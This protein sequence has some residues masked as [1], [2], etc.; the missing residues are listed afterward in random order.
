MT[1]T[2]LLRMQRLARPPPAILRHTLP[3]MR[4]A[5]TVVQ[6]FS[7]LVRFFAVRFGLLF[8]EE[9]VRENAV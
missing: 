3:T 4:T 7:Y 5:S 1:I 8:V 2:R 9:G 6:L